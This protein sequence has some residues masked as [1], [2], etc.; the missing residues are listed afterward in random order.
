LTGYELIILYPLSLPVKIKIDPL[1]FQYTLKFL[2]ILDRSSKTQLIGKVKIIKELEV[3]E[4][5]N[6]RPYKRQ[7]IVMSI[8]D[9][10]LS[11]LLIT[12]IHDKVMLLNSLKVGMK[13]K[14]F[15]EIKGGEN[16]LEESGYSLILIGWDIEL[17]N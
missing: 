13:I 5:K 10:N 9:G 1:E 7:S 11:E 2:E 14:V 4:V 6:S 8:D 3:R 17:I 16:E 12:F 15:T